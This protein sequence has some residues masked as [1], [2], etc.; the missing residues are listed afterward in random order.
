[1]MYEILYANQE[2]HQLCDQLVIEVRVTTGIACVTTA[3]NA[4]ISHV[5]CDS[6]SNVIVV[7]VFQVSG[8]YDA[9]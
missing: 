5:D 3:K 7:S 4:E 1:M 6:T 8:K 2:I 9:G